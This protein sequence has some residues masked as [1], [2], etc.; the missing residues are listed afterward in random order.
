MSMAS[1]LEIFKIGIGPSSSHT[2]G[3]MKIA[4]D[5]ASRVAADGRSVV[6]IEVELHG[7]LALTGKGHGTDT[8]VLLG[9]AGMMPESVD[10]DSVPS[11]IG[12]VTN[13]HTLPL[14][15]SDEPIAF[16]PERDMHF[17]S[18]CLPLHE[19]GMILRACF[20]DEGKLED[21]Y[22]STGGGFFCR[23][24][25]FG[26]PASASSVE[27]PHP[28]STAEEMIA[29]AEE[30]G[31]SVSGLV[32]LNEEAI[33]G[34][35][36]LEHHLADVW[37]VM[38]ES[39][40][41]G[42][43]VEGLL[44]GPL[45]LPRRAIGLARR[46]KSANALTNDPMVIVDWVNMYALAVS[47]ENA[48]GGRVVTAPTNGACGVIPAVLAYYDKFV[49][50]ADED[51]VA[52]FLLASGA[53]GALYKGNASISGAEVGC[54]GEVGVACSMAAGGLAEL[55]GASPRQLC[56]AA[57]IAMEHCL[58]LTCDP[59][60]GLVQVPCIE[61]N[62]IMAVKAINSA[63]M[64]MLRNTDPRVS[65][66]KVIETM[67]ETGRDMSA[68]YRETAAGGLAATVHCD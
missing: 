42:M 14:M 3:P 41:H 26:K 44:P 59:V 64:A 66:D 28:F 12:R 51:I 67:Y 50:P 35:D 63:R 5:F 57:E 16:V 45:R 2:V 49:A 20:C 37:R 1:V 24:E 53:I 54:Q 19:N 62:A 58:G 9:L 65:L 18:E 52:R 15:G 32:R 11:F 6:R 47:E 31:M 61:R 29:Q 60:G 23:A 22:Y 46:L 34:R 17:V 27:P 4:R 33:H 13:E 40:D 8:A 48:S 36:A 43:S 30:L 68:K 39:I 38:R 7:S 21:E 25:D 10:V 56:S 55:M